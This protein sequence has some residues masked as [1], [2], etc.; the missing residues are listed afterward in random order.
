MTVPMAI[1]LNVFICKQQNLPGKKNISV[2]DLADLGDKGKYKAML[3]VFF[4]F[5]R[6]Q[7]IHCFQAPLMLQRFMLHGSFISTVC[8]NGFINKLITGVAPPSVNL[9]LLCILGIQ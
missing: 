5:S 9:E 4:V 2:G 1:D 6:K 7:Q 3:R 8:F